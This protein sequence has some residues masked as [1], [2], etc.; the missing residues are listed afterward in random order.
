MLLRVH[1]KPGKRDKLVDCLIWKQQVARD[2][3]PGTLRHDFYYDPHDED[4]LYVYE[5]YRDTDAF[6]EHKANEPYKKMMDQ[7]RPE[8]IESVDVLLRFVEEIGTA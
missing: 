5:S 8:C 7:V 6:E 2:T 3:E 4:A 1:I